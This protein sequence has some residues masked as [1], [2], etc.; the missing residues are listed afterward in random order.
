LAER[1]RLA[2]ALV[3]GINEQIGSVRTAAGGVEVRLQWNVDPEQP[4]AVKAAR[5]LLLR[6][7]GGLADEERVALQEFVRARIDQAR[8]ELEENAPWEVR[9][10]ETLDYRS[11]HRFTLQLGHRDWDG[12]QPATSRRLQR[13]STG[14]RSIALHLPMLASIA[15][16]YTEPDGR[17]CECPR[18]ILLDEL[19]AGVDTANRAQLFR[20]FTAWDLDAV[21]TSDHEW[22]QYS[23]FDGIAIHHLHPSLGEDPVTS[24]RFTW[25]GRERALDPPAA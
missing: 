1:I 14:E 15:A 16:H 6:D 19:F 4:P 8:A 3:D 24:T 11:W 7:P 9:L 2:N 12:F 10:R 13:L 20:T 17:P 25:D 18:L 5:A 22:C 21:L 23:T